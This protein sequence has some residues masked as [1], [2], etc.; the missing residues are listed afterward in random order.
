M[1]AILR[2]WKE[3]GHA[4]KQD[5]RDAQEDGRRYTEGEFSDFI[6]ALRPSATRTARTVMAWDTCVA[7]PNLARP[8][9]ASWISASAARGDVMRQV[10][11][12]LFSIS[13]LDE[14]KGL[15]FDCIS[16]RGP[17]GLG[18]LQADSLGMGLQ[19]RPPVCRLPQRLAAPAGRIRLRQDPPGGGHR[20]LCGR[21]GRTHALPD[22]PRP[23]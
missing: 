9:S 1:E 2:R 21:H 19:Y 11:D 3:E 8:I 13:H 12:R 20:Q 4:K 23:A 10:R 18:E 7:R 6:R 15:T 5:R 16:S 22:R 17:N 14:L